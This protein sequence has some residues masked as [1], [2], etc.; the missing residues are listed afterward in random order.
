MIL[1][2]I[3]LTLIATY[4][5]IAILKFNQQGNSVAAKQTALQALVEQLSRLQIGLINRLLIESDFK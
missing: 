2:T 5:A 3:N 4:K 1:V